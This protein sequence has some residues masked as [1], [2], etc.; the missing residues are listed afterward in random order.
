MTKTSRVKSS[1]D[2]TD[3]VSD[4]FVI[5]I[6]V[7][8]KTAMVIRKFSLFENKNITIIEQR[9]PQFQQGIVDLTWRRRTHTGGRQAALSAAL[10]EKVKLWFSRLATDVSACMYKFGTARAQT[11]RIM[12]RD[13]RGALILDNVFVRFVLFWTC[14]SFVLS[15]IPFT[16][17]FRRV[18]LFRVNVYVHPKYLLRLY[19]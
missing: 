10:W 14:S 17:F 2:R 3:V 6:N 19:R 5:R 15:V 9:R 8:C 11:A 4:H 12:T 13:Q 18:I 7:A 1:H 16:V